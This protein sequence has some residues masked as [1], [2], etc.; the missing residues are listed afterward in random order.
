MAHAG[1]GCPIT[2]PSSLPCRRNKIDSRQESRYLFSWVLP[3]IR[4]R[5]LL[6][7]IKDPS[8]RAVTFQDRNAKGSRFG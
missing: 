6:L 1:P 2:L 5:C 3:F 7:S 8:L 4:S